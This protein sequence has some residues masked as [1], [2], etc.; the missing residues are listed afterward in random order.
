MQ[1]GLSIVAP[2]KPTF[3]A[4]CNGCGVCCQQELCQV[5]ADVFGPGAAPCPALLWLQGRFWCGLVLAE[6]HARR[7]DHTTLPLIEQTLAIGRGCDME[8]EL[9]KS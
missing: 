8:D 1:G 3:G 4:A 9:C 7:M 6:Y 2:P 5:G